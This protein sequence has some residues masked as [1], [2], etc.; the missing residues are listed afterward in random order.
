[1][2]FN[3]V[4]I[5]YTIRDA[6]L[7]SKIFEHVFNEA[8]EGIVV[9]NHQAQIIYMN[10]TALEIVE[11][12]Y[13]KVINRHVNDVIPNSRLPIILKTQKSERG[14]PQK[15]GSREG[16]V[17]RI[18]IIFHDKV[19]G[20]I[21]LVISKDAKVLEIM[22]S[23]LKLNINYSGQ[24]ENYYDRIGAK[25]SFENILGT[26]LIFKKVIEQAKKAANTPFNILLIGESGT[27]KELFAHAIHGESQANSFPFIRINC[28][29]IPA[30]LLESELF[31]H[32]KGAFLGAISTK[33][34]KFE[35]AEYG[36]ILLDQVGE[37]EL[38]LQSKLL[39]VIEEK[40]FERVGGSKPIPLNARILAATNK[41]L[42]DLC[43]N[44]K[45]RTDLYHQLNTIE[46]KIPPLR[47]RKEDILCLFEHYRKDY[48]VGNLSKEAFQA[49]LEYDWPGNVRELQNLIKRLFVL[50][51]NQKVIHPEDLP[52]PFGTEPLTQ[53]FLHDTEQGINLLEKKRVAEK[54]LIENM[55]K[56]VNGNKSKASELLQISRTSLYNK[57]KKYNISID[58]NNKR[59]E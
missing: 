22:M 27:G 35:L 21:G 57:I 40:E 34:G 51:E 56:Q 18:P 9:V 10:N 49:L 58:E 48:N 19:V 44:G 32:E 6:K 24:D 23:K 45:F 37:M 59:I 15:V 1:M 8:Y 52:E 53:N 12:D 26:S 41:N 50:N 29:A 55:L 38:A 4:S 20:A 54:I 7:R 46:I 28:A 36:T 17:H 30:N 39:R 33:K 47:E 3:N 42:A 5:S 13:D 43:K 31:G 11:K 25:Y 14:W 2:K 16:I